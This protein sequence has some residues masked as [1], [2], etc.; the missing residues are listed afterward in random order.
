MHIKNLGE[1][2]FVY[3][4]GIEVNFDCCEGSILSLKKRVAKMSA[5]MLDNKGLETPAVAPHVGAW[6]ETEL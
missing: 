1:S 4:Q 6:I 5:T 2:Q 3:Y